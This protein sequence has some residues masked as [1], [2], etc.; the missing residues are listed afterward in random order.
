MIMI[1]MIIPS[2]VGVGVEISDTMT[3]N[4]NPP[5]WLSEMPFP[6][7][8]VWQTRMK[9]VSRAYCQHCTPL[10]QPNAAPDALLFEV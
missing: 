6:A 5:S 4:I 8:R 2:S 1:I 10:S 9:D 3:Q 7:Q